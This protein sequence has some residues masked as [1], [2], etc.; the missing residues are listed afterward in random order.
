MLSFVRLIVNIL[1]AEAWV[2]WA[3]I[4]SKPIQRNRAKVPLHPVTT[5][6]RLQ[7]GRDLARMD[8]VEQDQHK[9]HECSIQN[10]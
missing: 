2:L 6:L 7:Q 3:R 10:V 9:E 8:P 5:Q 1:A 4:V